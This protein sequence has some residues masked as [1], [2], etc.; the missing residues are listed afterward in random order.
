MFLPI[1]LIRN[2]QMHWKRKVTVGALFGLGWIVIAAATIR[3]AYLGSDLTQRVNE[4]ATFKVPSPPWLA[5]W[6][7]VESGVGECFRDGTIGLTCMFLT[8]YDLAVIV[9][10]G[11]GLYREIKVISST[12]R[13][14]D[15][16]NYQN[17]GPY[18]KQGKSGRSGRSAQE[19]DI[20]ADINLGDYP[21]GT[22][23]ILNESSSQEELVEVGP[24]KGDKIVV[25]RS[26]MVSEVGKGV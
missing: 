24:S 15:D 11:P 13:G 2:L 8:L 1:A 25:T 5:L 10:C 26:V 16:N 12:R 14:Y 4:G 17:S 6:A 23:R 18:I 20:D 22:T 3:A 9:G 19:T 7:M 21:R